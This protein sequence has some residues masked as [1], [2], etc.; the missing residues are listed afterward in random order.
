MRHDARG[1]AAAAASTFLSPLGKSVHTLTL[2]NND[3][4]PALRRYSRSPRVT[5]PKRF[6]PRTT[7]VITMIL[8][9]TDPTDV[10]ATSAWS[11]MSARRHIGNVWVCNRRISAGSGQDVTTVHTSGMVHEYHFAQKSMHSCSSAA[12]QQATRAPR[13]A[14]VF[15]HHY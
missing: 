9:H 14:R 3:R 13:A 7:L 6:I 10:L 15:A 11:A 8:R 4:H 1:G 5:M 12:K 2:H